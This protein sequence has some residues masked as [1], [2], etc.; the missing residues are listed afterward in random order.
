MAR[1]SRQKPSIE[2]QSIVD[3]LVEHAR[4]ST[5]FPGDY[6]K[7]EAWLE[8]E[9]WDELIADLGEEYALKL[10]SLAGYNFIDD[11][12]LDHLDLEEGEG[13]TDS[14]RVRYARQLIETGLKG[15]D[16][17]LFVSVHSY[18]LFHGDGREAILGCSVETHGQAG[19]VVVCHGAFP[20]RSEFC[21]ALTAI[22]YLLLSEAE[23]LTD[24]MILELWK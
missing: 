1:K 4:Q 8:V 16:G 6:E 19:D 7:L 14:H 18:P 22:G 3:A 11:E 17:Y 24:S 9:G 12:L 15:D 20:S 2:L 23:N 10:H 21:A 5:P 13:V